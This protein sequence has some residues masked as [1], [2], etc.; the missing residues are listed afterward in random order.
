MTDL[1]NQRRMASAVLKCGQHRVWMDPDRAEEIAT[2]VTRADVRRL[3]SGGAITSK[4]VRGVSR[5]RARH[6]AAQK[7]KGRQVGAG[8]RKGAKY[9]RKPRKERWIQLIRPIRQELR[10]LREDEKIDRRT[11]RE[12]YRRAK[13][14]QFRSRAHMLAHM[15]TEKVLKEEAQ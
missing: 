7:A 10:T 13:G 9:A 2:A 6:T 15:R 4:P 5:G 8:S 12:Y 1:K 3:A 11:Y 14:G